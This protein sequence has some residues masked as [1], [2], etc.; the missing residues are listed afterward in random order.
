LATAISAGGQLEHPSDVNN[1]TTANPLS[2][3]GGVAG[4]VS[5]CRK[6][7]SKSR[8]VVFFILAGY[9]NKKITLSAQ[10]FNLFQV[11]PLIIIPGKNRKI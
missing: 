11:R 1:S 9:Y 5:V 2:F 4:R 10:F 8:V 3:F 6:N 7:K